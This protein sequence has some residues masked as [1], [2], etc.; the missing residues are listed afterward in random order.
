M[1]FLNWHLVYQ[2]LQNEGTERQY[3]T[4]DGSIDI[5]GRPVLKT[6]TGKWKACS[7]I[8]GMLFILFYCCLLKEKD[9]LMHKLVFL[10]VC[11]VVLLRTTRFLWGL[12]QFGELPHRETTPRKRLCSEE[13]YHMAR[14][15]LSHAPH[16][17]HLSRYLSWSILDHRRFHHCLFTRRCF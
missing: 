14:H 8:L 17:S 2:L 7:F 3:Y 11:R 10:A 4:G 6:K 12:D 13:C 16:R 15:M 1:L 9:T 5:R